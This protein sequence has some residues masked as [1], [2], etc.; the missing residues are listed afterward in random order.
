L[1]GFNPDP[2]ICRKG[3]DYYLAVSSFEWFPG[4]PIYHSKDMKNWKLYTHAL[5]TNQMTDLRRLP[6]AKG[7]WAPCL[8]YC[9]EEDLFYLLYSCMNNMNARFF[10]VDNYLIT[11]KDIE[12]PWSEPVFLHSAGFDPSILHDDNHRK[13]IVSLEWETREGFHKPGEIC[14]VEYDIMSKKVKGYPKRIWRGGTK[15]GCIE[16]PHLYKKD[17][18]YY[19]MTAEGGTGYGHSVTVARSKDVFGPYESD[20]CNPILTSTADFDEMD[21]DDATK[22]NRYNPNSYLQKSGHGSV[23]QTSLGEWYLVHHSGRPVLPELRCVL[24]RETCMQQMEWTAD[25]W[26][27]LTGGG[28]IAKEYF[29][30]SKL[31]EWKSEPFPKRRDFDEEVMPIDF[32]SPRN[33]YHE[34]ISLTERKGY[35]RM[36]GQ[37]SL[38]SLNRVSFIGQKLTSLKTTATVKMDFQPEV[39]QHYAGL[40]IYYDNMDYILLRKTFDEKQNTSV[41][42]LLRVENGDRRELL[43]KGIPVDTDVQLYFRIKVEDRETRFFW[44]LNG[45]SFEQIGDVYDTSEFS[46]EYCKNG[47]FTGTFIGMACVDA[48]FHNKCADFDFF[49]IQI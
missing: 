2:C 11:A 15:R 10:D 43:T 37:E 40:A 17:G 4:V 34:F 45:E 20:P 44:S 13:W 12:G 38:S 22:P 30:P 42:D 9:E 7:V 25:G 27:R 29:E 48:L 46:D 47:E 32:Y 18:Y 49:E 21:N 24:G 31:L 5:T 26:L 23:I 41:I 19:L 1:P 28:N 14:V 3:D 6:S 16:G 36:R 8:T 35:L 33:D 39:Y